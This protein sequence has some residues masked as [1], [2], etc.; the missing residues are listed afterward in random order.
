MRLTNGLLCIFAVAIAFIAVSD[1]LT[2]TANDDN[3][4]TQTTSRH[5]LDINQEERGRIGGPSTDGGTDK[6]SQLWPKFK[7]WFKRTF[8]FWEKKKANTTRR[9]RNQAGYYSMNNQ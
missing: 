9:L 7:A 2:S 5:L 8:Y 1:A 6:R 3:G 4:V